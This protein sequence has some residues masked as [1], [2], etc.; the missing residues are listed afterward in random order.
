ML[1]DVTQDANH[2]LRSRHILAPDVRTVRKALRDPSSVG[3]EIDADEESGN[4]EEQ[5]GQ[6]E[7]S[8]N[9][10]IVSNTMHLLCDHALTSHRRKT[11][12]SNSRAKLKFY[13]MTMHQTM[14]GMH[15][16]MRCEC[17]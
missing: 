6:G 13:R 1:I 17:D 7:S 16:G 4:E 14:T 9:A 12:Q 11:R 15:T 3:A 2:K 10:S 8:A 5:A